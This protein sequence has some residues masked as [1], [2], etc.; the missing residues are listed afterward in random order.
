MKTPLVF[1]FKHLQ[2]FI[3]K[4]E[5]ICSLF[6]PSLTSPSVKWFGLTTQISFIK[7]QLTIKGGPLHYLH[8]YHL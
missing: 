7:F 1:L 6:F 5:N 3:V 2:D 4:L 8:S